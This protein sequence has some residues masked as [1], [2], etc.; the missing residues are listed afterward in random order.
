LSIGTHKDIAF[1]VCAMLTCSI[2]KHVEGL[3]LSNL[4]SSYKNQD[5]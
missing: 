5:P 3:S 2:L 1:E 4:A